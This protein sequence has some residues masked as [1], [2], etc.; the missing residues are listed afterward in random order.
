MPDPGKQKHVK[1]GLF[2]SGEADV[3]APAMPGS[4]NR[5]SFPLLGMAGHADIDQDAA[6]PR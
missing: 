5:V 4:V 3:F 6:V 2:Q 1:L